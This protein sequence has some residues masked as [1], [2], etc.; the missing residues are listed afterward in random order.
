MAYPLYRS[1]FGDT[2][3]TKVF[4][5]GLAWETETPVMRRYFEQFGDILEA[6]IITDKNTGKSKGYGFVTFREPESAR[7]ACAN[8]NPVIDGRT[9]NCNIASLGRPRPSPPRGRNQGG[10]HFQRGAP[11]GAA[12]SYGAVTA[13]FPPLPPSLPPPPPPPPPPP[14]IYPSY[15]YAT[16]TPDY[17]YQQMPYNSQPQQPQYYHQLYGASSSGGGS[18]YFYGYSYSF[19]A[20]RGTAGTL[21]GDRTGARSVL[22]YPPQVQ[23]T[24]AYPPQYP[25]PRQLTRHPL[26]HSTDSQTPP[27]T[28]TETEAAGVPTSESPNST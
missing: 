14:I 5:G 26:P 2:T 11:P 17:W 12:P 28:S 20:P 13:P 25:A 27:H 6:V 8:P 16:C 23:G 24:S 18:P 15:G 1:Q 22:Y 7:R 3:F 4:V 9:A 19:Q 10:S 21:H